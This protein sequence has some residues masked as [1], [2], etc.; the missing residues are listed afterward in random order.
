M[1]HILFEGRRLAFWSAG[2]GSS[3][4]LIHGSL[5]TSSTWRRAAANL[6][7]AGLRLIAPDLPG[8]GES[9]AEPENCPNLVE[10]ET[11]AIEAL[12]QAQ[13][14]PVML[15]AHSYGCSVALLAAL[16][17]RI[18]VRA[19]VLFEPTFVALLRQAGEREAY[20]GIERFVEDYRRGF[21]AGD[22]HAVRG[23]IDLW[24]GAG[25]YDAM[26]EAAR[27]AIAAW[28]PRNL[29]HW[30]AAFEPVPE[31]ER[32]DSIRVPTTLVQSERAHRVARLIVRHMHE[33]I[34]RSRVAEV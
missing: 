12:A 5:A 3:V 13:G 21:V 7:G 32:I 9:E 14:G 24:G 18:A 10:Y 31:L 15:V 17:G 6:E 25:S 23:V 11:R 4:I 27:N 16:H 2:S 33:R 26:P 34:A 19:L 8:W 29:R 1:E 22:K 20:E 28:V 30:Q